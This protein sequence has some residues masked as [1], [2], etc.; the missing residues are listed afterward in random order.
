MGRKSSKSK[1]N[2]RKN[3]KKKSKFSKVHSNSHSKSK[4]HGNKMNDLES[5][6]S[7]I[8]RGEIR[9]IGTFF[10]FFKLRKTNNSQK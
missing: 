7:A 8:K 6:A 3:S 4:K 10:F 5:V 2:K 9:K 1:R